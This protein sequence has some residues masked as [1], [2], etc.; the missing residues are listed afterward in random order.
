MLILPCISKQRQ[1]QGDFVLSIVF[2]HNFPK[3]VL[4][5][6][7][8]E[9]ATS[10][11]AADLI[12]LNVP[13]EAFQNVKVLFVDL[14]GTCLDWHSSITRALP[15]TDTFLPKADVGSGSGQSSLRSQFALRWRQGF[16]NEIHARF[17]RGE[18]QEDIDVT[19]RR[20]LDRLLDA[21]A[22]ANSDI[23]ASWSEA[24]KLAAV[25]AWHSMRAWP[26]VAVA[27]KRLRTKYQV[28]VLAN[29]TTK[30]QLDLMR[31]SGLEF[32]MLFSSQLLGLTKPDRRVYEKVVELVGGGE[33]REE[34]CLMVAAHAYD[35]RA[36]KEVGFMT[37]YI[38][39]WT[40]D[41]EEDMDIVKG[42]CDGFV[43]GRGG[44]EVCGLAR[45][46]SLLGV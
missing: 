1:L 19:H 14:M 33:L 6:I 7:V 25:N 29:G 31:S 20:V 43:D 3:L 37:V 15:A 36:A 4:P 32:D 18:E 39:R 12:H 45:V 17:Q 8:V 10:N 24:Q 2:V 41:R 22:N 9:Q 21:G 40:E 5:S 38:E 13:K 46:A 28:F 16:F 42:E 35:L 34:E 27:L 11:M 23:D 26:D 44:S 30:L